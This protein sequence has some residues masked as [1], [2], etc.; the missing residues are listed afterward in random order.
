MIKFRIRE[1]E[2]LID[3]EDLKIIE[4]HKWRVSSGGYVIRNSNDKNKSR[5]IYLHKEILK[6]KDNKIMVDHKDGNTLN[7]QKSNLRTCTH[8][9]NMRN[10]KVFKSSKSGYKGVVFDGTSGKWRLSLYI[11]FDDKIEAAKTYDKIAKLLYGDFAR[12]NFPN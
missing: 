2:I 11:R 6:L 9:E 10:R 4:S 7:N 1:K 12:L 8:T 5:H 3:D